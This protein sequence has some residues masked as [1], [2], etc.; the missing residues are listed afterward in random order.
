M[1]GFSPSTPVSPVSITPPM[2]HTQLHLHV[3]LTRRTHWR[4]PGTLQT[5]MLSR[6][7]EQNCDDCRQAEGD[8]RELSVI[9]RLFQSCAYLCTHGRTPLPRGVYYNLN[10]ANWGHT[11]CRTTPISPVNYAIKRPLPASLTQTTS[12]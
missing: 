5:A 2:L 1:T 4:S 11:P 12:Q 6:K 8:N 10:I 7:S 9:T 3:A